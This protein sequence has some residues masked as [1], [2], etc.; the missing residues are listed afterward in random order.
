MT[1]VIYH[2]NGKNVQRKVHHDSKQRPYIIYEK[3]R[4]FLSK[5]KNRIE[6]QMHTHTGGQ[7]AKYSTTPQQNFQ[8]NDTDMAD[9]LNID[10][11]AN[12]AEKEGKN[13]YRI[14]L[15]NNETWESYINLAITHGTPLYIYPVS[16]NNTNMRQAIIITN[17]D[18][19]I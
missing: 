16:Q 6:H 13:V 3:K 10:T 19:P 17:K 7:M 12:K 4:L 18:V 9:V 14:I 5:V 11:I 1:T 8:Y 2:V 15:A